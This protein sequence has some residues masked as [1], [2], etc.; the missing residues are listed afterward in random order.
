VQALVGKPIDITVQA[1]DD[2]SGVKEA[3]LFLGKPKDG[4]PPAGAKL[5]PA[6]SLNRDCTQWQAQIPGQ[7]EAGPIDVTAQVTNRVGLSSFV[8][9][10]ITI[11]DQA[12]S[13]GGGNSG[14]QGQLLEGNRPQ[15]NLPVTL[16]D[17]SGGV[18]GTA[19]TDAQGKF[20]FDKLKPGKYTVSAVKDSSQRKGQADVEVQAGQSAEVSISLSL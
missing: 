19:T 9:T 3:N 13:T 10:S 20:Q 1:I 4:K 8:T 12:P 18:K 2:I 16:K 7:K 11:L 6:K 15:P 17:A 5:I 14:I